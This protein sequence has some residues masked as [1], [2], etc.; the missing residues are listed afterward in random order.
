[1][2]KEEKGRKRQDFDSLL[3]TDLTS[4]R[5]YLSKMRLQRVVAFAKLSKL[6]YRKRHGGFL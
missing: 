4:E 1:M 6:F 5:I 3:I 2:G